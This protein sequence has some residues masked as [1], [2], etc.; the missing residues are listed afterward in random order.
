M[1]NFKLWNNKNQEVLNNQVATPNLKQENSNQIGNPLIRRPKGRPPGTARFKGP[2][3]VSTKSN[4]AGSRTQ[5]KCGLCNN[6]GHNHATCP[7]NPSRKKRR[8]A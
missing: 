2:L 3:E 7:S 4:A 8:E 1:G 5:N 6:V